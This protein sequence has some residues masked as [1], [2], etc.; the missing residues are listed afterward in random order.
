MSPLEMF[1]FALKLY[2]EIITPPNWYCV[3]F[4][5]FVQKLQA[6]WHIHTIKNHN[7]ATKKREYEFWCNFCVRG[8][9]IPRSLL[10]LSQSHLEILCVV[11]NGWL[12]TLQLMYA[13]TNANRNTNR[14][15]AR[16]RDG[17]E[18]RLVVNAERKR[19]TQIIAIIII[20]I[21]LK[22]YNGHLLLMLFSSLCTH[23]PS[24]CAP[25]CR[26]TP[27]FSS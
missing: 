6:L 1:R 11:F 10:L 25:V 2:H 9:V 26:C 20:V 19:M 12:D 15:R 7:E 18:E 21:K 17:K 5:A 8:C 14:V 23:T 27:N 4:H 13:N 24:P 22:C 3:S 16:A